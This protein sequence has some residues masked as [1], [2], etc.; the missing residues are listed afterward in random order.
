MDAQRQD[1]IMYLESETLHE[2]ASHEQNDVNKHPG[3]Y[4]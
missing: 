1:P 3:Q 4:H 2:E